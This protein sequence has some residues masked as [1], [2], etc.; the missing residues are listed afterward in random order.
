MLSKLSANSRNGIWFSSLQYEHTATPA[1]SSTDNEG[2][3]N[4]SARVLFR[5]RSPK[6]SNFS[7]MSRVS[8]SNGKDFYAIHTNRFSTRVVRNRI[9]TAKKTMRR[10]QTANTAN[11]AICVYLCHLYGFCRKSSLFVVTG[12]CYLHDLLRKATILRYKNWK[13]N[14]PKTTRLAS[15]DAASLPQMLLHNWQ[16]SHPVLKLHHGKRQ[17]QYFWHFSSHGWM[18]HPKMGRR[19]FELFLSDL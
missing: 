6:L 15:L 11:I 2:K 5:R 4:S 3:W 13:S 9:A 7:S 10:L 19:S 14:L 12:L 1:N 16:Q 17:N 18:S 8:T